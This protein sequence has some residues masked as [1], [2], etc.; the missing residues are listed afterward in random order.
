MTQRPLPPLVRAR[1]EDVAFLHWTV[2]RAAVRA[3]LPG[4]LEPDEYAGE[5]YVGLVLLRMRGAAPLGVPVPWLGSFCQVN[6][7]LY[8]RDRAGGRG[9][10][11]RSMDAGRLLPA[12]VARA[13][14]LPYYWARVRIARRGADV[15]YDVR[16]RWP[17]V[18]GARARVTV[19]VG[20]AIAAPDPLQ[21][22]LTEVPA[23]FSVHAGRL[24]RLPLVHSPWPLHRAAA[25]EVDARLLAA[26][27]LE[28]PSTPP[29][30]VLWSPGL[31]A[32]FG[33][34]RDASQ[35]LR[36]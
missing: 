1:L 27:G 5:C 4:S 36:R 30:N 9:V 33:R 18:A 32:R 29:A 10:V 11:F 14:G 31:A 2:P 8:V 3:L 34:P 19:E 16:R 26:A 17:T 21:L 20:P 25:S 13:V 35:G 7:R 23:L 6:V 24:V 15:H 12:V 22:W 28:R